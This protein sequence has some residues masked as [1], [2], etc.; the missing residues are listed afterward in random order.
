MDQG[1]LQKRPIKPKAED[2]RQNPRTKQKHQ[3]AAFGKRRNNGARDHHG[4][5]VVFTMDHGGGGM[6]VHPLLPPAALVSFVPFR[7]PAR[8]FWFLPF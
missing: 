6:A 7:F 2:P 8:F 3:N 1:R 5:P 4:L